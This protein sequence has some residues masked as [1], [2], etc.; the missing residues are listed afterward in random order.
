[1][2]TR[3]QFT[4]A[5]QTIGCEVEVIM[6]VDHVES[7]GSGFL[8]DGQ[9]VI[10][11]E[12]HIFWKRLKAHG[13]DPNEYI[14]GNEDILYP[15]WGTKP[16]GKSSE[17]HARLA[18]AVKIHREAALESASWGRYQIL[19]LNWELAGASS[20][21]DFINKIYKGEY[22]HLQLFVNFIKATHLDDELR[23]LDFRG[24]ARGYNGALYY[25]HEYDVKLCKAYESIKKGS[26]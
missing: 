13:L 6:A 16:Y 9:P 18:R 2:I 14:T 24:F 26:P 8:S 21:Q 25:K 10:L 19:G 23:N 1:M 22:E 7:G 12:P 4:L 5:A 17:Q 20:L 3:D 15:V 11:F